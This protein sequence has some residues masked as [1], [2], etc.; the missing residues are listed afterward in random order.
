MYTV[1]I[2]LLHSDWDRF[3]QVQQIRGVRIKKE[4]C[5]NQVRKCVCVHVCVKCVYVCVHLCVCM[6]VYVC[7]LSV[8]MCV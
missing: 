6:C 3:T 5:Q 7:M 2:I 8:C 4:S 1:C